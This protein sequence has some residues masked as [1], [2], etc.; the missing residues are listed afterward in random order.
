MK[1]HFEIIVPLGN[2]PESR[3]VNYLLLGNS[4]FS[5]RFGYTAN[6]GAISHYLPVCQN[7]VGKMMVDPEF[8][9]AKKIYDQCVN[10][11]LLC[12]GQLMKFSCP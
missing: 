11:D 9:R 1:V 8:F 5:S 4:T 7:C 2:Q 6:S 3:S 10:W 12:R